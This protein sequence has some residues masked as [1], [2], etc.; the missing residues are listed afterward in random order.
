MSPSRVHIIHVGHMS[1]KGTQALLKS[2]V[3]VVR[4]VFG[5]DVSFSV[6]TV[7]VEG[8]RRLG[9]PLN[10][11]LPPVVDVPYERADLF[12]RRLGFKRGSLRYKFSA[13]ASLVLMLFQAVLSVFSA[14]LV[15]A[16]LRGFYRSD[17]FESVKNCDVVVSYS[18]ENFKEGASFLPSN[19]Y[20]ILTWWTM[21]V[22]RTWDVLVARFYGRPVVVFPNSVGPFRSFV[23]RFLARLALNRCCLVLVR[24]PVSDRMVRSLGVYAPRVLTSD[25]TWLFDSTVN[26]EIDDDS[27]PRLGVSPGVYGYVFSEEE[28]RRHVASYAEALD[29]AVERFGFSVVFLPHYVS[30]FRYDDLEVSKM[31]WRRM[32]NR[33]RARIVNVKKAEEFKALLDRMDMVIS[34]KMHPAVLALSG[35]VPTLCVAYDHKQVGLFE[36]LGMDECVILLNE[37]SGERLFSKICYVWNNRERMRMFLD[38]RVPSIRRNIRETI[39]YAL[40]LVGPVDVSKRTSK[41]L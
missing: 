16:G 21:L 37:L 19:V 29:R 5:G 13:L 15:K 32:R 9:L 6:S 10:A 11:V 24:E 20:W 33:D 4:E 27:G 26:M 25:T 3:A 8:V 35:G 22:S 41:K 38:K 36:S 30:G 17:V 1:N 12:A 23:G 2:D 40:S 34:S 7:D 14:V 28:M 18:D 31:I 39:G